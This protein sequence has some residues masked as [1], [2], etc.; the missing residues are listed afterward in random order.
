MPKKLLKV[1]PEVKNS[2]SVKEYSEN[3]IESDLRKT[4]KK[5]LNLEYIINNHDQELKQKKEELDLTKQEFERLKF[6]K[7]NL[8][9]CTC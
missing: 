4:E 3:K 2:M 1:E 7:N 5:I 8:H 6:V 9:L